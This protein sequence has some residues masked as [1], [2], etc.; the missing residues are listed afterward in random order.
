MVDMMMSS[1]SLMDET[2]STN[3]SDGW[4]KNCGEIWNYHCPT[5]GI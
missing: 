3:V 1:Y 5:N 2:K 4:E